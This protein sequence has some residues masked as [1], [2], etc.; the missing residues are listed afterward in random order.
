MGCGDALYPFC[1]DSSQPASGLQQIAHRRGLH[2]SRFFDGKPAKAGGIF[3]EDRMVRMELDWRGFSAV[4]GPWCEQ[5]AQVNFQAREDVGF[6]NLFLGQ[7]LK[8]DE[9]AGLVEDVYQLSRAF[10]VGITW[11]Q[12]FHDEIGGAGPCLCLWEVYKK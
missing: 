2:S 7:G 9:F 10:P 1:S 3:F 8:A 12:Y 5:L 11:I 6:E 4:F